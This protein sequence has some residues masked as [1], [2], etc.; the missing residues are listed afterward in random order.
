MEKYNNSTYIS[1]QFI[2]NNLL[3]FIFI[4][5]ILAYSPTWAQSKTT[6]KK[7]YNN[8]LTLGVDAGLYQIKM[9]HVETKYE[10]KFLESSTRI[11]L[12]KY[13]KNGL[14]I[15][16][17]YMYGLNRIGPIFDNTDSRLSYIRVH[18]TR[19]YMLSTSY[20]YI[21]SPLARLNTK[22]GIGS[23][24]FKETYEG[25]LTEISA[26][27]NS[28]Q[29]LNIGVNYNYFLSKNISTQIGVEY[30]IGKDIYQLPL[31]YIGLTYYITNP[32]ITRIGRKCPDFF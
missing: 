24:T 18:N 9:V 27:N 30:L 15:E 23:M 10:Q 21:L 13:F 32:I 31:G 2:K 25:N 22:I 20:D 29:L 26:R 8:S 3:F 19:I 5:F 4:S 17:S 6:L 11:R 1:F 28:S 14:K 7:R 12:G 16:A